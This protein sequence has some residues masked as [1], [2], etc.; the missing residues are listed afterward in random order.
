M[1]VFSP[2][3]TVRLGSNRGKKKIFG[4]NAGPLGGI[5]SKKTLWMAG[6]CVGPQ[7]PVD[8]GFSSASGGSD[9]RRAGQ[10]GFGLRCLRRVGLARGAVVKQSFVCI[11]GGNLEKERLEFQQKVAIARAMHDLI[12]T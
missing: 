4:H 3:I 7:Y 2:L 1:R 9:T 6:L 5:V 12:P 11:F 10:I 8:H